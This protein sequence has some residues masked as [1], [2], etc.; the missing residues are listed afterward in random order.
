MINS[1]SSVSFKAATPANDPISRPGKYSMVPKENLVS[2]KKNNHK[3]LKWIAG[4]ATTALAVCGLL[5]AGNKQGWF[6]KLG[7]KELESATLLKKASHY[8]GEA[9]EFLTKKAWEPTVKFVTE[10]IPA[11]CKALWAKIRPGKAEAVA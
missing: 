7:K 11:K 4:L 8:L 1:V 9:G 3:A 6:T 10:T 5:I 2:E